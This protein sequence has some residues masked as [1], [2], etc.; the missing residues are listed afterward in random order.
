MFTEQQKA[1]TF[2][3]I[4]NILESQDLQIMSEDQS[5]PWGGFFVLAED[6]AQIF[7]NTYFDGNRS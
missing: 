3:E 7:A 5:R 4:R 1:A 2:L 6:Q